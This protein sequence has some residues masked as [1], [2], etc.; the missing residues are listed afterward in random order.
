[1]LSAPFHWQLCIECLV[2][3]SA[4]NRSFDV[5]T[6]SEGEV[7]LLQNLYTNIAFHSYCSIKH[8][9]RVVLEGV[10]EENTFEIGEHP[11]HR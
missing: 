11:D 1:M 7:R 4:K 10:K 8:T 3:E 6:N 9:F 2:L 5:I